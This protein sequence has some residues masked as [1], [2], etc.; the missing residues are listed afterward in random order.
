MAA[1]RKV[2][3]KKVPKAPATR[4]FKSATFSRAARKAGIPDKELCEAA[5]ELTSR[6]GD[7]LGGVWKKRLRNGDYRSIVFEKVGVWWIFVHLF[8]KQDEKNISDDALLGFKRLAKDFR[9]LPQ[10]KFDVL[11]SA[12][13]LLEICK[14]G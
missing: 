11:V 5:A 10:A 4:V 7:N 9:A 12:G 3:A 1:P 8:D 6:L 14:N 2:P 13:K